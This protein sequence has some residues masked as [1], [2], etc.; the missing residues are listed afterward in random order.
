LSEERQIGVAAYGIYLG[1]GNQTQDRNEFLTQLE[2]VAQLLRSTRPTAVNLFWAISRML[3]TA[4]ETIASVEQLKQV[5]LK[6]A[7]MI[8][9]EDLQTCQAIGAHGLEVLPTIP[10]KLSILTHCNAGALATAGYGTAL[11][12]C[13]PRGLRLARVYADETSSLT[14]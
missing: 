2:E 5:L 3:K 10:S 9:A 14:G 13:A 8:N 7:Q 12:M 11:G 1:R 4:Y 6:T